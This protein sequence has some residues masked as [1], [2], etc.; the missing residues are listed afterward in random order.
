MI[1]LMMDNL[2]CKLDSLL[3][4]LGSEFYRVNFKLACDALDAE[5][6]DTEMIP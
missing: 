2:H 4:F 6:I 3:K 5:K 1:G